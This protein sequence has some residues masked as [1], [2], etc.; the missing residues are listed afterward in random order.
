MLDLKYIR[1]N[2]ETVKTAVRDKNESADIDGILKLDV[3]RRELLANAE[4]LKQERNT[5]SKKIA[6]LKKSGE[7]ASELM[8]KMKEVSGKIS[9]MDS[10]LR[11]IEKE[12]HN[13]L[14]T[15]PNIP[16]P[17]VPVGTQEE[18]DII[19]R[20]W[21]EK[22]QF[23]FK[24]RTHW[25]LGEING[26]LDLPRGAA[27][28]GSGFPVLRGAGA[29]MQRALINYMLDTHIN[30]HGYLELSVPFLVTRETMIGTGQLPKLEFDMYRTTDDLFLIPTGEVPVTNLHK[31]EIIPGK[32]L[33]MNYVAYTPCF[34]REAG[35]YGKDTR[36][37][38]RIH[39]FDKVELVKICEPEQ[40]YDRLEELL[41]EAEAVVQAL[42]LPYR[43]SILCTGDMSF[44]SAKTYDIEVY[45]AGVDKYL[46]ASSCS[47]FEDFQA[48]R[49]DIRFKRT[50]ESKPELPHTLNGSGL[51]LPRTIIAIIENYQMRDG[52]IKIPEV[53]RDYMD[54]MEFIQAINEN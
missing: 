13:L 51:A 2:I 26:I 44:A 47:N 39:Q 40:S 28:A 4:A 7:D 29:R 54:G 17:D 9:D 49:S 25:E 10:Q 35:S 27:V 18:D 42:E 31:K 33:P 53:L 48:R 38:I 21:G 6:E 5:N 30:R 23:D 41:K 34:R 11:D 50:P 3:K 8:T 19:V 36:G 14:L 46:E 45:S 24:P 16:N 22:P 1:Q 20:E 32:E 37:I 52:R 43:V 15:V 12:L